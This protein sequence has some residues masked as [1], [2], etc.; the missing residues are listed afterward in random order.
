MS[1]IKTYKL[2]LPKFQFKIQTLSL[3]FNLRKEKCLVISIF[4]PFLDSLTRF[5]DSLTG[6]VDFFSITKDNFIVRGDF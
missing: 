6:I 4:E 1:L 3:E 5:L 2:S